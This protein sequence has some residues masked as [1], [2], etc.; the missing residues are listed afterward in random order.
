MTHIVY[1]VEE[2]RI[3]LKNT[4]VPRSEDRV[5]SGNPR[6][7]HGGDFLSQQGLLQPQ[8]RTLLLP[9]ASLASD[10]DHFLS[11]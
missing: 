6:K 11:P 3:S 4:F 2:S 8:P 9:L 5:T 7:V 1:C 10:C